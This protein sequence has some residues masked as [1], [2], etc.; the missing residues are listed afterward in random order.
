MTN[1]MF[2]REWAVGYIDM[3]FI[4]KFRTKRMDLHIEKRDL[5]KTKILRQIGESA[6]QFL[7]KVA[8]PPTKP[9]KLGIFFQKYN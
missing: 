9:Q 8:S 5:W 6:R 2:S 3:L 4:E 7:R 1:E